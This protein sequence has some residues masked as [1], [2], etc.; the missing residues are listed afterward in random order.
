ML[1][2]QQ[3]QLVTALTEMYYQLRKA[4]AWEGP[5]LDESDGHP[6]T[7]D[8]LSALD[9]LD[10]DGKFSDLQISEEA[11]DKRDFKM[12]LDHASIARRRLHAQASS[13]V[14]HSYQERSGATT[15]GDRRSIQPEQSSPTPS[16]DRPSV[17]SPL[18]TQS[19]FSICEASLQL[20]NTE[21]SLAQHRPF[22]E[23]PSFMNDKRPAISEWE[24]ALV[25]MNETYQAYYD[26]SKA[27]GASGSTWESAPVHLDSRQY[28][29][30]SDN[31][32]EMPDTYDLFHFDWIECDSSWQPEMAT[33]AT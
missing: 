12:N 26:E 7:H 21:A 32:F 2:Q 22:Q 19:T 17:T 11:C 15:T 18:A 23:S 25:K 31:A 4:S 3:A 33:W 16:F 29:L 14:A 6:S 20:P 30:A 8:I 10:I 1:E 9:L 27:F 13:K 24:H 28:L 5:S